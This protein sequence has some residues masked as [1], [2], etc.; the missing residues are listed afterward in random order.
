MSLFDQR[1]SCGQ[2]FG[3]THQIF[4]R[5]KSLFNFNHGN[6]V[7]DGSLEALDDLDDF[8]GPVA[9]PLGK[10]DQLSCPSDQ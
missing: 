4:G 10:C 1:P 6:P 9:L 2:S 8:V 3:V 5:G 7:L